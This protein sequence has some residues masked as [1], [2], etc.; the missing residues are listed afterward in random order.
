MFMFLMVVISCLCLLVSDYLVW[1]SVF[2]VST[3]IFI[4]LMSG[5]LSVGSLMCYYLIQ[6]ICGYFFLVL[7]GF[8]SFFVLMLKSGS[9]PLH[10]W[11][12]SVVS[13]LRG[14]GL[15]WF[16]TV[17]KLP[18]FFVMM[19]FLISSSF[20]FLFL[21]M[22]FCY[23][24]IFFLRFWSS[25]VL[26]VSTES[27]NWLLLL[28]MFVGGG[29]LFMVF[30][31]YLVM[32]FIIG[33]FYGEDLNFMS[34]EMIMVFFNVP[35][36]ISF[37]LKILT[38]VFSVQLNYCVLVLLLFMP[39]VSLGIIFWFFYIMFCGANFN[40]KSNLVFF[41]FPVMILVFF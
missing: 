33:F 41:L 9:A 30:I 4:F 32:V 39:L 34:W 5:Y 15:V 19:N 1:W 35:F 12:F 40:L 37:L 38:L 28:S 24:Q 31:Y 26:V 29:V 10:F 16:L 6:E 27:F 13:F 36:C 2:V 14:W 22:L 11:I 21:G 20:Y 25:M 8:M 18:Y 3:M 23:F 17:Q 7:G